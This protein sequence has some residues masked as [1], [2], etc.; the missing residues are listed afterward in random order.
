MEDKE[1]QL[2]NMGNEA[3]KL[4]GTEVFTS[5]INAMVDG[6]LQAFGN[7]KP[8]ETDVREQSYY[9]YRALVDLVGTLQQRVSIKNEIVAKYAEANSDN[10]KE[11]E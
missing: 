1:E 5:T 11:A 3:E 8:E 10:N 6:T 2:I 7:T 9:H 4:L